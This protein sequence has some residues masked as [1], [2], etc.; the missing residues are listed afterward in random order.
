MSKR[1]RL[2]VLDFGGQTAHLITKRLRAEGFY[3][4]VASPAADWR[5][6]EDAR[7]LILSGGPSSLSDPD[8]PEMNLEILN[9]LEVPV[10][11]L[12]YGHYV[13]AN[14]FMARVRPA[15][16]REYGRAELRLNPEV[17]C[18]LF[19]GLEPEEQ[20]WMSHADEVTELGWGAVPIGRTENCRY[21]AIWYRSR[22]AYGLQFHPEMADTPSG[23]KILANFARICEMEPNWNVEA[24]LAEMEAET[25]EK[26]GDRKVLVLVSGGVDSFVNF[27]FLNRTLGPEK[28]VGLFIDNGFLRKDEAKEVMARFS[29]LGYKNVKFE[30]AAETFLIAVSELTDPQEKRQAIGDT[31]ID[32]ANA[33]INFYGLQGC[34]LAQGTLYPDVIESG[35]SA[36]AATIKTHHNRSKKAVMMIE[37]GEIVEPL[38]NLYKDEVRKIGL[39]LGAPEDIVWRHPFPGPGLAINVLCAKGELERD[40]QLEFELAQ[41]EMAR[42]AELVKLPDGWF[43]EVLPVKSTGVQGDQRTYAFPV[44][45]TFPDRSIED[46]PAPVELAEVMR[47]ITNCCRYINRVVVRMSKFYLGSRPAKRQVTVCEEP[48][49][50]T[51]REVDAIVLENLRQFGWY[52]RVFQYATILLPLGA[53]SQ[54]CQMVL[55]PV[56]SEDVMTAQAARLPYCILEEIENEI[57]RKQ[58][59]W[60]RKIEAVY[61]DITDKPPGTFMWE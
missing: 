47:E 29:E 12:C 8:A 7:G 10:L 45:L 32:V 26:V 18:E 43:Y 2:V 52:R 44:A 48:E 15:T 9:E 38:R 24:M 54:N 30:D 49:L 57:E 20:V 56:V 36:H 37:K 4:E 55:R 27:L 40:D 58:W 33:A 3:A 39:T 14:Y 61:Y 34:V 13:L 60:P 16:E 31:Y 23:G 21:A 42:M 50:K 35:G 1:E 5:E 41:D 17:S 25:R 59:A 46:W 19:D 28:V 51:I 11:G 53:A 22:D 6:I